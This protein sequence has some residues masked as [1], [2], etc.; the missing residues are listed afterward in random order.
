MQEMTLAVGDI[1]ESPGN[2]KPE[3]LELHSGRLALS[4]LPTGVKFR[5]TAITEDGTIRLEPLRVK[6]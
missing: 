4:Q 2:Q 3:L 5:V 6:E 1:I